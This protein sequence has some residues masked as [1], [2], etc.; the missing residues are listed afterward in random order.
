MIAA[1]ARYTEQIYPV[2]KLVPLT[3]EMA[4]RVSEYRHTQRISSENEAIRQLIAAGLQ[5]AK[6]TPPG[7]AG[8][9]RKPVAPTKR[10]ARSK[11]SSAPQTAPAQPATK[12]AQLRAM[13]ESGLSHAS[14]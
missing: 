12:E 14:E 2:K 3:S 7:G 5:A 9:E 8:G 11:R 4:E 13:R 10:A 6:S 1:M